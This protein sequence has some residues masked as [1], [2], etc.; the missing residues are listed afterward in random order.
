MTTNNS[1]HILYVYDEIDYYV[2]NAVIYISTGIEQGHHLILIDNPSAYE[3]IY[4]KLLNQWSEQVINE[5]IS[6]L[7]NRLY[8]HQNGNFHSG[9]IIKNFKDIINGFKEQKTPIRTWAHVEWDEEDSDMNIA[10]K[11]E[12]FERK[13][14]AAVREEGVVSVCAYD[15]HALNASLQNT[16]LRTH[17]YLMTDQELVKS[18]LYAGHSQDEDK[19][20]FPSLFVQQQLYQEQKNMLIEKQAAEEA[21]KAK[22]AFLAMMSHE[23][24]TPMNGILGMTQLLMDTPLAEEQVEY[25]RII[26][27]SGAALLKIVNDIL[28]YSKNEAGHTRLYLEPF[29]IR[30]VLGEAMDLLKIQAT[31]KQLELSAHVH[32][33]V[34]ERLIGDSS[35]LRQVL[36]NL[37]SNA[38]KFTTE[39]EIF[40]SVDSL[41]DEDGKCEIRFSVRDTG[42]GV[43]AALIPRLFDPFYQIENS[44]TRKQE[45]TGLGL[46]ISKQLVELMSGAIWMEPRSE[47]GS[48]FTFTALFESCSETC[49]LA[50]SS[51]RIVRESTDLNILL[52]DHN[53]VNQAVLQNMLSRWGYSSITALQGSLVKEAVERHKI[54][55]IFIDVH[56]TAADGFSIVR[57]IRDGLPYAGYQPYIIAVTTLEG[58]IREE[59]RSEGMNYF[60]EKPISAESLKNILDQITEDMVSRQQT[61]VNCRGLS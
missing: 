56:R 17:E 28:D 24:R 52:A 29:S 35:R 53:E 41:S 22:S 51:D 37:I 31:A 5:R 13:A 9:Q 27:S 43:D 57:Q 36:M 10:Q 15:G 23:I 55:I 11:L 20:I 50:S 40:I 60:L 48:N 38:I 32:S 33:S 47:R 49:E 26:Q 54:D 30:N 21:N 4:Y 18:N 1:G 6:Y 42:I 59:Y 58:N 19:V 61:A 44:V 16:L 8:Y 12:E 46:A 2:D 34:P 45:G 7:D 14:D 39:G 25:T 3:R